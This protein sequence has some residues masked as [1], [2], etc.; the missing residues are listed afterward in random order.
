V[1]KG[2]VTGFFQMF[3]SSVANNDDLRTSSKELQ[4][5]RE[6]EASWTHSKTECHTKNLISFCANF[7]VFYMTI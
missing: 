3:Y 5:R 4:H 7:G 2:E 1:V 6:F